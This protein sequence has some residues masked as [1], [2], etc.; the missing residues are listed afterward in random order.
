MKVRR[1]I[2]RPAAL[3]P[4]EVQVWRGREAGLPHLGDRLTALYTLAREHQ[5]TPA[6]RVERREALTVQDHH[7]V[8]EA[9]DPIV[10]VHDQ[11]SARSDDR[12]AFGR[13]DVEP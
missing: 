9:G 4:L 12:R 6:V 3:A 5:R 13:A 10:A 8:A 1:R 11:A 7:D 2:A